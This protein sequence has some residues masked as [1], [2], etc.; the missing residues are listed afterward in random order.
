MSKAIYILGAIALA[1]SV[2]VAT[3]AIAAHIMMR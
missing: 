1:S 2:G 3:L